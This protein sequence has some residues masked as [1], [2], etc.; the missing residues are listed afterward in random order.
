MH[1]LTA[2]GLL[3]TAK[4]YFGLTKPNV[5]WL[6]VFTGLAG[7]VAGAG[8]IPDPF[9]AALAVV[10]ITTGSAG[11]ETVSNYL[12]RDIDAVMR[13]T[14][15]RALPRGLVKPEWK[16]LL[17]GL[18][19][20]AVSLA[21]AVFINLQTFVF[22]LAGML[23]YLLVYIIFTKRR[24]PINIIL[25]GFAGG[26][27][28]M[29]G[30]AAA[31]GEATLEAWILASL[32]VLWIPAH[33]WSLALRYKE[34]YMRAGV[35]MLPVVLSER[36]AIRCIAST[37]ILFIIFSAAPYLLYP[38]KYGLLYL[39]VAGISGAA[40]TCYSFRLILKPTKENAWRLFRL[41]SPQLA[42]LMAAVIIENL[43]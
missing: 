25:G 14:A 40:L 20:L 16:A 31:A 37:V 2:T 26:A 43:L 29:A 30:Y 38:S 12:E 36:R 32:I 35:P 33:V 7:L 9:T 23:D 8:G 10:T 15:R 24:S 28:L 1:S 18:V 41:T 42:I 4:I 11:S 6:L 34:D 21:T 5:W 13:R 19:L 27:P 39:V 22:M 17:L 3:T